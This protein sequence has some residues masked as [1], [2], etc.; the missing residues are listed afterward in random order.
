MKTAP[1]HI[2]FVGNSY[3]HGKYQPVL[4]YNNRNVTDLNFGLSSDNPR[5]QRIATEPGPWGG[6]PGI[7]AKL[8]A[9]ALLNYQV[10]IE[11]VSARGLAFHANPENQATA[12]IY[13][14]QWDVV[15]L[16]DKSIGALP[17]QRQG[18]LPAFLKA[19][20]ALEQGIHAANPHAQIYL[21]ATWPRADLTYLPGGVYY[22]ESIQ[23]MAEDLYRGY[24]QAAQ[25]SQCHPIYVGNAWLAA[26]DANIAVRNPYQP[27]S[28]TQI[29]LWGH[30]HSHASVFGSFLSALM[31]Y[32]AVTGLDP[33]QLGYA[34][35]AQDLGISA[36]VTRKLAEI[37][38]LI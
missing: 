33:R 31:I 28:T 1:K 38:H 26:I 8:V 14:A 11:A 23:T 2:L 4:S 15:I 34:Q 18:R 9:E 25:A 7:F 17:K 24:A 19:V 35:A 3:T 20:T 27:I 16:Q 22:G 29:N 36:E 30:D 12:I 6:I 10:S 21:Y 5:H 37:A 32:T 13:Q